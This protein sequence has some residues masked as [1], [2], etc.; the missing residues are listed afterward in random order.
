M[1]KKSRC[2][3]YVEPQR[4]YPIKSVV[5]TL[6]A[7]NITRASFRFAEDVMSINDVDQ[8]QTALV[9]GTFPRENFMTYKCAVPDSLTISFNT[10]HVQKLLKNVRK[11]DRM[12]IFLPSVSDDAPVRMGITIKPAAGPAD[13]EMPRSETIFV[14]VQVEKSKEIIQTIDNSFYHHPMVVGAGNVQKIKK[15]LSMARNIDVAIY[16]DQYISFSCNNGMYSDM[17]ELGDLPDDVDP[18]ADLFRANYSVA[19]FNFIVKLP[20]LTKS[21]QFYAPKGGDVA[22]PLKLKM[23]ADSLGPIEIYIKDTDLIAAEA[24]KKARN[25]DIGDVVTTA[26]RATKRKKAVEEPKEPEVLVVPLCGKGRGRRV[27]S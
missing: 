8:Q 11:K 9:N 15:L 27:K 16:Q 10:R 14:V 20:G 26:R 18:E 13:A 1:Y 3:I 19:K 6:A 21:I 17:V 22:Y 5:D 24:A 25:N 12:V 4:A 7:H 23:Q 2:P